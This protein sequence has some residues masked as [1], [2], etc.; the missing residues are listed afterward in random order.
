M[1][2][3]GENNISYA[4]IHRLKHFQQNKVLDPMAPGNKNIN[5]EAK[6]GANFYNGNTSIWPAVVSKKK[7]RKGGVP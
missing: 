5:T 4:S 1:R 7:I 2:N 3:D 6:Y